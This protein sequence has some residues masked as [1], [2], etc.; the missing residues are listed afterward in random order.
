LNDREVTASWTDVQSTSITV[1]AIL[2]LSQDDQIN[3]KII[4]GTILDGSA[5][6]RMILTSWE[7]QLA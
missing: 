7:T 4:Q 2:T 6:N 1:P 3:F 5:N